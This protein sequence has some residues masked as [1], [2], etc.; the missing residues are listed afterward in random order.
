MTDTL[1][2][3]DAFNALN[4]F[5]AKGF[6][7]VRDALNSARWADWSPPTLRAGAV[8]GSRCL[9]DQPAVVDMALALREHPTL[10]TLIPDG[11]VAVQCTYFEKS[12][13]RNWL[14]PIHQDLSIPVARRVEVPD[15]RG[16]RGWSEKE[17]TTFVQAPVEVLEQLVAVR[18]HL[19][20]CGER[21]GPLRVVPGSHRSGVQSPQQAIETRERLGEAVCM[22]DV[23]DALVL[24]PLALHASSKST[25]T[26]R[27]RVL[28]VV[29]GPARLPDGL[30]WAIAVPSRG[31]GEQPSQRTHAA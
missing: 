8:G 20:P 19:D 11:H 12:S 21:D 9:L 15:E 3:L 7:L 31:Q 22:A 6:A 2:S 27:R 1:S 5:N 18:W 30:S 28:H 16:W 24:R 23:G 17:G 10:R 14:V 25:G 26:S 29:F 13:D 4:A